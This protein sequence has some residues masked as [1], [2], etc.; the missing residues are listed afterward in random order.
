MWGLGESFIND[1]WVYKQIIYKLFSD[2][3][4]TWCGK[5]VET[6]TKKLCKQLNS[7][8]RGPKQRNIPGTSLYDGV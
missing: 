8:I 6:A 4:E 7:L 1:I 3:I 5:I 2:I